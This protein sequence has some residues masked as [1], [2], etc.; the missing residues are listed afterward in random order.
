MVIVGLERVADPERTEGFSVTGEK[1]K[2]RTVSWFVRN[3]DYVRH[4]PYAEY[5]WVKRADTGK[6]VGIRARFFTKLVGVFW[7]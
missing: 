4:Q 2:L 6:R 5:H 3:V 1:I 7:L